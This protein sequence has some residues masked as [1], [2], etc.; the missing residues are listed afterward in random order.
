MACFTCGSRTLSP[1]FKALS[2]AA[3]KY[4]SSRL[5]SAGLLA[6]SPDWLSRTAVCARCP[7]YTLHNGAAHCGRPL[8]KQ[9][10]RTPND[11]CGCPLAAKARAPEEHCPLTARHEPATQTAGRCDCKWCTSKTPNS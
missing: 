5:R 8:L 9:P 6:T 3:A 7:L 2:R 11:G 4:A 1:V 10:V